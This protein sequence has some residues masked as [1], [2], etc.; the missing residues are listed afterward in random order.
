MPYISFSR[1]F[2]YSKRIFD[3]LST[4]RDTVVERRGAKTIKAIVGKASHSG[5]TSALICIGA[6]GSKVKCRQVKISESKDGRHPAWKYS[7]TITL[8]L[9]GK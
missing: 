9:D 2:K 6:T 3:D 8:D 4:R 1:N 7:K 5:F